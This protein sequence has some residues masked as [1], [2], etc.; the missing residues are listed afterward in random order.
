MATTRP[1]NAKTPFQIHNDQ[2]DSVEEEHEEAMDE[3]R[4]DM[5]DV[6]HDEEEEY[7]DG[8]SDDSDDVVDPKVQEDMDRFEETFKGIKDRFRLINRIGEGNSHIRLFPGTI[9]T[10][11]RHVFHCIQG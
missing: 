4:G 6:E 11:Y 5:E 7:S 2:E 10:R 8:C 9:L 1:R 3:S